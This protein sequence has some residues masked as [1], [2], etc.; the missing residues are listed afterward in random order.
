M[1]N[2][3]RKK[4]KQSLILLL[5]ILIAFGNYLVSI[6]ATQTEKVIPITPNEDFFKVSIDYFDIDPV[7]YRLIVTGEVNNPLSLTLDDIKALNVTSEIVRLTCVSYQY[8]KDLTGV[9]NW[10]GVR[11]SYILNLAEININ[12][13]VDI[14]FHTPDLSV[15]GYSTSLK[16][17]EAFW[18]DVILAYEMNE[19]PLPKAHGYP[20]RVVCPRFFGFKWIKWLTYINVCSEEYIGF[21]PQE[22]YSDSPY[23]DVDLPI[24]YS[25]PPSSY[26]STSTSTTQ[27]VSWF[28]FELFLSTLAVLTI[29]RSRRKRF[30]T[31]IYSE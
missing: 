13:T 17:E 8:S 16:P 11:L 22:G 3:I 12:N 14:S 6:T 15:S 23:V 9:A 31:T 29:T 4:R 28:G 10:T 18:E 20:I 30:L 25:V 27:P 2:Y 26:I 1:R 5:V 7:D 21:Y 24:Y 19:E